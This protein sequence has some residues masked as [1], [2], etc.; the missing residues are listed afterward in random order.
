MNDIS[1]RMMFLHQFVRSIIEGYPFPQVEKKSADMISPE[2]KE[3]VILNPAQPHPQLAETPYTI[4]GPQKIVAI[5]EIEQETPP[6]L[7]KQPQQTQP[8]KNPLELLL[9]DTTV[10]SI[11][12]TGIGQPL[13]IRKKGTLS[14]TTLQ[15]SKEQIE[16]TLKEL[17]RQANTPI[18]EGMIKTE[19]PTWSLI[20]VLSEFGGNRFLF[21]RK[22][23]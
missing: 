14:Q 22:R 10:E 2:I 6:L 5:K 4:H 7:K 11:E 8:Q 13:L 1:P 9:E 3:R 15:L 18:V 23:N 17:A 16:K 20:A 21:E 12:C 19:T